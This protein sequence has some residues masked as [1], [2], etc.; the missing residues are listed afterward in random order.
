META[1]ATVGEVLTGG[2]QLF[3]A[4]VP[5]AWLLAALLALAN[6]FLFRAVAGR[7]G[8]SSLYF[9]PWGVVGFALG[10]LLAA[11]VGSWLP[12]LGDVR[13]IE[14]S[15]GAWVLLTIGNLRTT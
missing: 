7:E 1:L 6:V 10:N 9:V 12:T 3:Y 8:H 14:A 13:V 4:V 15:L 2:L 11:L 5:P